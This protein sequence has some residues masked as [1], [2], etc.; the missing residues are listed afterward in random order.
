MKK[1]KQAKTLL[2]RL[3]QKIA[4]RI[5]ATVVIEPEWRIVGQITFKNRRR[6][7]FRYSSIDVNTLGA[8]EIAKDKD[9]ANFFMK[10]M[11]YPTIPGRTFFS[12]E[13]CEIIGS[14]RNRDAAY[15]YARNIGLPVIVKPNSGSQGIGVFKVHNRKEFY[16]AIRFVLARDRT[17]LV[18]QV[19]SGKDYRIVVL[20]DKVISAYERIPLYVVGDGARSIKQLMQEKQRRFIAERRDTHIKITDERI[21]QKLAREKLTLSS[22]PSRG[23][24]T[25][26]AGKRKPVIGRRGAGCYRT[27]PP[28]FC[29]SCDS[30]YEGYGSAAL[31]R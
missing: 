9:F 20:D 27:N 1:T 28:R 25:V 21:S 31:R 8:S 24:N 22:V 7:Y 13:L 10:R 26:S 2:G 3:F 11:G 14:H 15:R 6:R 4:P 23:E 17:G 30:S 5:G 19:V 12:D 29:N 16:Q 18:Q